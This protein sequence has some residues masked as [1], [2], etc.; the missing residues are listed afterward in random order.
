MFLVVDYAEYLDELRDQVCGRC[1][2]RDPERYPWPGCEDHA[3]EPWLP[4]SVESIHDAE[5]FDELDPALLA[6]LVGAVPSLDERRRQGELVLRRAARPSRKD[7][8]PVA[9]II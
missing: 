8:V 2:E 6:R 3:V 9:G 1:P 7:H 4:G 5:G